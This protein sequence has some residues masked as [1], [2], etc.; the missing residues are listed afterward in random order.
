M[1]LH[2]FFSFAAF[3][4]TYSFMISLFLFATCSVIYLLKI[5]KWVFS[6][7]L[8]H[9]SSGQWLIMVLHSFMCFIGLRIFLLYYVVL[10]PLPILFKLFKQVFSPSFQLVC[11]FRT[12]ADHGCPQLPVFF[13]LKNPFPL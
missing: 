3:S 4:N 7:S 5:F 8:K 11:F 2:S 1:V 6:F 10:V 9:V 13:F 12:M